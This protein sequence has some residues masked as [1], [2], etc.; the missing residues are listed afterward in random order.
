M[1]GVAGGLRIHLRIDDVRRH[2]GCEPGFDHRLVRRDVLA[3]D[4]FERTLVA[5]HGDMRVRHGIAVT[6]EMLGDGGHAAL[7][8][9][10]HEAGAEPADR[11]RIKMQRAIADDAA[12]AVVEIEHRREAEVD[13]VRAELGRDDVADGRGRLARRLAVAVPELAE[14][15]HRRNRRE[16]FAKA[17]HS[18]ALVVDADRQRRLAQALQV[19]AQGEQLL[20]ILIVPGK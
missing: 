18:P 8:E 2:D 10:A 4:L 5:R 15:P 3:R 20:R 7:R 9:A 6:R 12:A 16:T 1:R 11:N 14:L 13:A 19:L 17:L